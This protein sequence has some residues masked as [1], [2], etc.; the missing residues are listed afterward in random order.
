MK[1]MFAIF[2]ALVVSASAFAQGGSY[3]ALGAVKTQNK[4]FAA[5]INSSVGALTK[6]MIVCADIGDDNA[7]GVDL[8]YAAGAKAL[9]V[10]TDTSCAVGA[11]CKVQTK[12]YF[13]DALFKYVATTNSVAGGV[14]YATTDGKVYAATAAAGLY[15][16]GIAFD[17][18]A[19]ADGTLEIL[20]DL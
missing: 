19:S 3:D 10:I 5:V 18:S 16:M 1:T 2:F 7:V 20:I 11:R 13:A 14:L 12:G 17:V 8:C 6:G 4:S 15:P 9:G